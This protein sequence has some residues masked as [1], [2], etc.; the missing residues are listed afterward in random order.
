[1]GQQADHLVN[2]VQYGETDALNLHILR[3]AQRPIHKLPGIVPLFAFRKRRHH[4]MDFH[5][6]VC[7]A[8]A[9]VFFQTKFFLKADAFHFCARRAQM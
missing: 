8:Q 6:R 3:V 5:P 2:A 4:L 7:P 1:M 9:L